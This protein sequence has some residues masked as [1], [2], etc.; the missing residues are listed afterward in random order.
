MSH[1]SRASCCFGPFSL[2]ILLLNLAHFHMYLHYQ[3][4]PPPLDSHTSRF[5]SKSTI[6]CGDEAGFDNSASLANQATHH[7]PWNLR[8][9]TQNYKFNT[10][11]YCTHWD[12][13]HL[14]G[15][16]LFWIWNWCGCWNTVG[17]FWCWFGCNIIIYIILC[18]GVLLLLLILELWK[19]EF[20]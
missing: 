11:N 12:I 5:L 20:F 19:V 6:P 17:G 3:T 1:C 4:L 18:P 10:N 8:T 7:P 15:D 9:I 14:H 13:T 2:V 16:T